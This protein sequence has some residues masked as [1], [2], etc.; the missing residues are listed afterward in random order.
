MYG[1]RLRV[2]CFSLC[3]SGYYH[4]NYTCA[5]CSVIPNCVSCTSAYYC[6]SC[7]GILVPSYNKMSCEC[8][9]GG[10]NVDCSPCPFDCYKCLSNGS[11]TNCSSNVSHRHLIGDRCVPLPG[12]Y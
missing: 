7:S 8:P 4:V 6:T 3:S 12:Y 10:N 5:S 2:T 1:V 11:C 9:S